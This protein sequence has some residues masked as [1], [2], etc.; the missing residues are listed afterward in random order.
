M[1]G[2]FLERLPQN[3]VEQEDLLDSEVWNENFFLI[4]PHPKVYQKIKN[5]REM[6][7]D[8]VNPN[9]FK[10]RGGL[11]LKN[12]KTF[13]KIIKKRHNI[14]N[15]VIR[16][17][18]VPGL[19]EFPSK[20]VLK[21]KKS[22]PTNKNILVILVDFKDR[23][24]KT[25]PEDVQDTLFS[26]NKIPTGSVSDYFHE[27]S[28]GNL[29]ITGS[30]FGWHRARRKYANYVDSNYINQ[31]TLKWTMKK[32]RKL[33]E[34]VLLQVKETEKSLDFS[35]YDLNND[36]KVDIL[37]IIYAGGGAEMEGDLSNIFPHRGFFQRP[38]KL[39][40]NV[41]ADNYIMM[42]ELPSHNIGGFCHEIA[43][44]LG[45]P[46]LYYP[47]HTSS[48]VG[49]WCLMG[50][51]CY[52]NNGRTPAHLNPW[53]KCHLG[54]TEP[55]MIQDQPKVY[56]I[57]QITDESKKIYKLEIQGTRGKEYFLVE[58]RQQKGFDAF[59]PGHGMLIW[60]VNEN[61]AKGNFPNLNP[62]Q[63]FLTLEQ[64]DGK[65]SLEERTIQFKLNQP[66]VS[67]E[68]NVGGYG[69]PYPGKTNNR[70]F[71]SES[72]PN[73]SSYKGRKSNVSIN[74]ISASSEIMTATMGNKISMRKF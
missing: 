46:D 1:G 43:H 61:N 26:Q 21:E 42:H 51:G 54:W 55:E 58:N 44:T 41:V 39:Q 6:L 47:D 50:L 18:K 60:H 62:S 65:H 33:A 8:G 5:T 74:L 63:L 19:K 10:E 25:P 73:S 3:H 29:E 12:Y 35:K 34:E 52:N 11:S 23:E 31:N 2:L 71:D 22:I 68:D 56:E 37:I 53:F 28:W 9:K 64:A 13:L 15:T 57:P 45:I 66:Y 17:N 59:L 24:N 4:H 27:V 32:A 72:R 69:D 16:Q 70:S 36:G 14:L 7:D 38:I 48:V 40:D 49:A 20:E 67:L 30:V